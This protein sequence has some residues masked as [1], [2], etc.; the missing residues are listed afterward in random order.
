YRVRLA[1][2]RESIGHKMANEP[3]SSRPHV[4]R[5]GKHGFPPPAGPSPA[6]RACRHIA[7]SR[8]ADLE[9]DRL[10]SR[11]LIGH[12][13]GLWSPGVPGKDERRV[14]ILPATV[15][16]IS[17]PAAIEQVRLSP[18]HSVIDEEIGPLRVKIGHRTGTEG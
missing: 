10:G 18:V 13:Q 1:W 3:F 7:L 8:V 6:Q 16:V 9:V 17:H 11:I 14:H 12:Y 5:Q 4:S 2:M 15:F